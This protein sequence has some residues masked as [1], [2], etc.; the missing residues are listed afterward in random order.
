MWFV[1]EWGRFSSGIINH[2]QIFIN[3]FQHHPDVQEITVVRYPL[4]E[5]GTMPPFYQEFQGIKYYT[6]RISMEYQDAF[7]N[8]LQEDLKFSERLKIRL[9]KAILKLKRIKRLDT[10]KIKK[11]GKIEYGLAGFASAQLPF[12]NP[13]QK[14]IGH[15]IAKLHPDIIQSHLEL[16]SVAAS[17]AKDSAKAH[18]S[19]QV[20]ISEETASLPPRT[21]P[22]VFW[23][24]L[25]DARQWLI[26]NNAVD[27]YVAV[28][29]H[30]KRNLLTAGIKSEQIRV[31]QS[32]IV[33]EHL[34]PINKLEA[35]TKLGIPQDKRVILSVG[36]VIE[37]KRFIDIIRILK[38]LPDNVLFYFKRS[39][40]TSDDF[41]P[42]ALNMI[43]KE[44]KKQHLENR[45]IINSEIIPYEKMHV[46][47]SAA[48]VAVFP[49]LY[50]PF[51]M[52]VAEAMAAERPL[53]VYNSGFLPEF[54]K[55]NGFVVEPMNLEELQNKI[56][57]LLNDPALAEEMGLKGPDLVKQFDIHI[58][59]EKLLNLYREYL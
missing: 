8:L 36:R 49:F 34:K 14:Q 37:R 52:C 7:S 54:I 53:I 10:E 23:N 19:Y 13:F 1:P 57:T 12:P 22:K 11:W 15:C 41:F 51:G 5:H 47:Y 38:N 20:L 26:D 59:G 2:S 6:P 28:S 48:D 29:D 40:C 44:I 25:D 50:E 58:I 3:Y 4:P 33:L 24:R 46:I 16:F 30:A 27:T 43:Q 39:L 32:P 31:I 18:M 21:I 55:G 56:K 45:V 9:F 42:S 35:R 17:L